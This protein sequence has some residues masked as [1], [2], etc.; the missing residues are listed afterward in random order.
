MS[1][2]ASCS[3]ASHSQPPILGLLEFCSRSAACATKRGKERRTTNNA[4]PREISPRTQSKSSRIVT[5]AP[6]LSISS[7]ERRH[8]RIDATVA[9]RIYAQLDDLT[10]SK[11]RPQKKRG[12][13]A[14]RRRGQLARCS[15]P[16]RTPEPACSC[17]PISAFPW[18][19]ACHRFPSKS[20]FFLPFSEGL[21]QP[22]SS[23]SI[24]SDTRRQLQ[25]TP[26]PA[27]HSFGDLAA[28]SPP[29]DI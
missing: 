29:L 17:R 12:K 18:S 4:K 28:S 20:T 8:S 22:R 3:I 21:K 14:A 13:Y 27:S 16:R 10:T 1:F 15:T 2:V 23:N 6:L 5:S 24:P 11:F 19:S 26:A 25:Q 9:T 7:F